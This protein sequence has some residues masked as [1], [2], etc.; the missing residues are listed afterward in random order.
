MADVTIDQLTSVTPADG[1]S[2][3]LYDLSAAITARATVA[4]LLA[5]IPRRNDLVSYTPSLLF[6]GGNTGMTFSIQQGGYQQVGRIVQFWAR[7]VLTA[8]GSATGAAQVTL[9]VV[10]QAQYTPL[11]VH[12]AGLNVAVLAAVVTGAGVIS[13]YANALTAALANATDASFAATS[14]LYLAGTYLAAAEQT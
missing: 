4:N 3:P 7:F 13:L 1:D 6:G 9:P 11:A 10:P 8:K 12:G 2:I 5:M 14:T